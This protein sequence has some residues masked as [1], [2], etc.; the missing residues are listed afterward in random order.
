METKE[1]LA[2]IHSAILIFMIQSGIMSFVLPQ[3]LAT[4]FGTNGWI[5][6]FGFGLL[7]T[8]NIGMI[9]LVYKLGHGQSIFQILER[10]IPKLLLAPLYIG[11]AAAWSLLGNLAGKEYVLV[12]EMY[13]FPTTHPMLFDF[14]LDVLVVWLLTKGIYNMAKASTVFYFLFIWMI[15]LLF[16]F[17]SDFKWVRMTPFFFKGANYSFVENFD[18]YSAF[19][20]YELSMLL[21]DYTNRKTKLIQ[22]T[23]W[24][25]AFTT[26][27]YLYLGVLTFGLFSLQQLKNKLLPV[28]DLLAY[29]R[30]PFLERVENLF[31]GFFM[32]AVIFSVLMYVWAATEA[33]KRLMPKVRGE[34]IGTVLM[35]CSFMVS[36]IPKGLDDV[37][38]W[39]DLLSVIETGVAFGLPLLLLAVLLFQRMR[40]RP[41]HE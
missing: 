1:K 39:L 37:G 12:F 13:S 15:V 38:E 30:L 41:S 40:G 27:T 17:Y 33:M 25:N 7:A 35:F 18:I 24:A 20:G 21:F 4:N 11:L 9:G 28:M 36:F 34:V 19:L 22:G 5:T 8:L 32:F 14:I 6:L 31:F 23:F 29:I 2:P 10:S 16:F 26:S 3:R